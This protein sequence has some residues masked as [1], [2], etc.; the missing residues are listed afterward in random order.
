ML[1]GM[2]G[3]ILV[4]FLTGFFSSA[5][6]FEVDLVGALGIW[7]SDWLAN[8]DTS[9]AGSY[10]FA[11]HLF[12]GGVFGI[13]YAVIFR[14]TGAAGWRFGMTLGLLHW[15]LSGLAIGQLAMRYPQ[16]LG[17]LPADAPFETAAG[18]AQI[19]W[20]LLMHLVFGGLLGSSFEILATPAK[21]IQAGRSAREDKERDETRQ[22][23]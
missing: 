9:S 15:F 13:V 5:G 17:F 16:M 1:L 14:I 23:A 12:G 8:G 22:A 7:L 21:A 11:A 10:G 20:L 4:S 19:G 18:T 2:V 6:V 3:A